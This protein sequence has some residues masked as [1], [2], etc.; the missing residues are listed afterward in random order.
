MI[1]RSLSIKHNKNQFT[2]IEILICFSLSTILIAFIFFY[3]NF[4]TR[5]SKKIEIAKEKV[6]NRAFLQVKLNKIFSNIEQ[7]KNFYTKGKDR[8]ISL[9]F[10]FE[11]GVD[12]NKEFC[13]LINARILLK[14][15]NLVIETC[16]FKENILKIDKRREQ[17]IFKNIKNI[18]FKFFDSRISEKENEFL[19]WEENTQYVP[20]IIF[21]DIEECGV[22]FN[23]AFVLGDV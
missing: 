10:S 22:F 13:G 16:S 18:K 5:T 3:I 1:N 17:V 19:K 12:I 2:L 9:F 11:N 4:F 15:D 8:D 14:N 21:L 20:E 6:L 23:Y 7:P